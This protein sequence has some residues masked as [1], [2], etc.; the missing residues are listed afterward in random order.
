MATPHVA[1]VASLLVNK[2]PQLTTA[3]LRQS[4]LEGVDKLPQFDGRLV[5][6]A[7]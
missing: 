3:Q 1:S 7:G 6:A 4:V 5:A 2:Y